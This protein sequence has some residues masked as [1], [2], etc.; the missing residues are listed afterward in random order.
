MA[1][2]IQKSRDRLAADRANRQ[3]IRS[4]RAVTL[5]TVVPFVAHNMKTPLTIVAQLAKSVRDG[6]TEDNEDRDSLE[7]ITTQVE[8][9]F[10]LLE[11]IA[12]YRKLGDLAN[13]EVNVRRSLA[14]VC[15]F[16]KEY[17]LIKGI[18]LEKDY[19]T[20]PDLVIEIEELDFVQVLT[21]LLFNADEMFALLEEE[22]D[23]RGGPSEYRIVVKAELLQA[24]PEQRTD[25]DRV[26][27]SVADNGRE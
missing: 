9:C 5:G 11:S 25:D 18:K 15:E 26:L 12:H 22:R 3:M 14:T 4:T 10:K 21:N 2:L 16:F 23:A 13:T 8:L 17:F 27:I 1:M 19:L 24:D 7:S 6:M 20:E